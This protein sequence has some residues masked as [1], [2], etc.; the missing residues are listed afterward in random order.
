MGRAVAANELRCLMSLAGRLREVAH[1]DQRDSDQA[2]YML[3][4]EALEKHGAWLA[5]HLPDQHAAA[6]DAKLYRRVDVII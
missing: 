3:A 5:V 4:A 2:L 6:D 1:T